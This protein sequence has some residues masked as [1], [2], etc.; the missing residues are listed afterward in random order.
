M[1]LTD[2][3]IMPFGKFKGVALAN[4]PAYYLLWL[5]EQS[6]CSADMK[7]YIE[8]NMEILQSEA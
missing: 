5:Y 2:K 4:V 6:Y 1:T 8:D 3:S 7:E